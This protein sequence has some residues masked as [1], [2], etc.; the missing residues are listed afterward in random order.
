MN[1]FNIVTP[2]KGS[3]CFLLFR[4]EIISIYFG[5]HRSKVDTN[6]IECRKSKLWA[7]KA[8]YSLDMSKDFNP[9]KLISHQEFF[10]TQVSKRMIG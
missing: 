2:T 3:P 6:I 8:C 4:D 5:E 7:C 1:T 10:H 9:C